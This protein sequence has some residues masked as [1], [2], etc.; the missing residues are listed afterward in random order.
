[1]WTSSR[2]LRVGYDVSPPSKGD[3]CVSHLGEQEWSLATRATRVG[4]GREMRPNCEQSMKQAFPTAKDFFLLFSNC[5]Q[6]QFRLF[7]DVAETVGARST[8]HM[9][10]FTPFAHE[11][12]KT[13][14][15]AGITVSFFYTVVDLRVGHSFILA[16]SPRGWHICWRRRSHSLLRRLRLSALSLDFSLVSLLFR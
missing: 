13:R 6:F 14:T 15:N 7:C 10:F 11:C 5:V 9:T 4:R 2:E 16:I 8:V 1:M 3:F 12:A